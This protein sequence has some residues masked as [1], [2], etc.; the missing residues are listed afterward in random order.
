MLLEANSLLGIG[1]RWKEPANTHRQGSRRPH[2]LRCLSR[3]YYMLAM[4]GNGNQ[5][6]APVSDI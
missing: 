1:K 2:Y 6:A 5:E 3:G 4:E